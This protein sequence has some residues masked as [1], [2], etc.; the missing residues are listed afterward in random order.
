MHE[1]LQHAC[2]DLAAWIDPDKCAAMAQHWHWLRQWNATFNLTAIADDAQAA[3]LHY[4]DSL[5][6]LP[7]L[8]RG[9]I[10]DVGS[11]AGFPGLPLAIARPDWSFVL[12]EPRRK[13]QSFLEMAV[14]RL[15]LRQVRVLGGRIQDAPSQTF[16]HVVTRATFADDATLLSTRRWLQPGGSLLAYRNASQEPLP[17]CTRVPYALSRGEPRALDILG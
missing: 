12:M 5:A 11:G 10:L 14:A 17:G 4:R 2:E 6:A 13:R 9:P 16:A 1:R 15:G 7:Y 8:E 3:W